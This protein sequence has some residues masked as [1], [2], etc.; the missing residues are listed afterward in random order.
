MN[1]GPIC[2]PRKRKL[3]CHWCRGPHRSDRC[4]NRDGATV[5]LYGSTDPVTK[6][7]VPPPGTKVR[8][9]CIPTTMHSDQLTEALKSLR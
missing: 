7:Y 9:L 5:K 3:R 8:Y 6:A 2:A 4:H 1:E